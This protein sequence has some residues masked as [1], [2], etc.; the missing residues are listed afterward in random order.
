VPDH[1]PRIEAS[2]ILSGAAPRSRTWRPLGEAANWL[3][4]RG[5]TLVPH[6]AF[7]GYD[8][9]GLHDD[10]P[11]STTWT[12]HAYIL[13]RAATLR[14]LWI[15]RVNGGTGTFDFADF[16]G[17]TATYAAPIPTAPIET[18]Y[19]LHVESVGTPSDIATAETCTIET[20]TSTLTIESIGVV[21]LPRGT[22]DDETPSDEAGVEV[23]TLGGGQPI[24]HDATTAGEGLSLDI[25]RSLDLAQTIAQRNSLAHHWGDETRP[26]D[27]TSTSLV[28]VF[29]QAFLVL[30]RYMDA[31]TVDVTVW[32]R[33]RMDTASATGEIVVTADDPGD[34]DTISVDSTTWSWKSVTLTVDAEDLDGV[35][36]ART[37]A[38]PCAI[39]LEM[40]RLTGTGGIAIG[41]VSIL[42][43]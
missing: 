30:P 35:Y 16:S 18:R 8:E 39:T 37:G 3:L 29:E 6:A 17:G 14:R 9:F 10:I 27:T 15:L 43:A 12:G 2:D 32:V 19:I 28:T 11:T 20:S 22:L 5:S 38:N 23:G 21:D 26:L 34:S 7:W 36:G 13:P 24:Y 41:S 4:G 42:P 40:R 33:C 25:V 31:T 1:A